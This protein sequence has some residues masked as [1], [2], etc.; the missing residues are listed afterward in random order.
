MR[1]LI[2]TRWIYYHVYNWIFRIH[3]C[4]D[5]RLCHKW[6]FV[7]K[8]VIYFIIAKNGN[9]GLFI[10]NEWKKANARVLRNNFR[11]T[12]FLYSICVFPM[13]F[14]TSVLFQLYRNRKIISNKSCN[15]ALKY[16]LEESIYAEKRAFIFK[17]NSFVNQLTPRTLLYLHLKRVILN[18]LSILIIR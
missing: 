9:T 16:S 12:D 15:V 4:I 3:F 13:K 10:W 7:L 2:Y 6:H 8:Y 18:N 17:W 1:H 14:F 11:D 5:W